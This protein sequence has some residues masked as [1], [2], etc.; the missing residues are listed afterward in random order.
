MTRRTRPQKN[1][2]AAW[3]GGQRAKANAGPLPRCTYTPHGTSTPLR[4]P[5]APGENRHHSAGSKARIGVQRVRR[6]H[7]A[8]WEEHA[9]SFSPSHSLCSCSGPAAA[10]PVFVKSVPA[11][12]PEC[13]ADMRPVRRGPIGTTVSL[14]LQS[15]G[16]AGVLFCRQVR[17]F[18]S[19]EGLWNWNPGNKNVLL[20]YH[21]CPVPWPLRVCH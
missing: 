6:G 2:L 1:R 8:L 17:G 4:V 7:V 15:N 11:N 16:S 13:A 18:P 5:K 10:K 20:A 19:G 12:L 9:A 21:D 3:C 14:L